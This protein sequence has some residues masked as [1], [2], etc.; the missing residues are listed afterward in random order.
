[1]AAFKRYLFAS[2]VVLVL[3]N[4][5]SYIEANMRFVPDDPDLFSSCEDHPGT[6]GM[7]DLADISETVIDLDDDVITISGDATIVWDVDPDE[8]IEVGSMKYL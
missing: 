7:N 5:V 6:N 8:R 2:S 4:Y 3:L 1:M